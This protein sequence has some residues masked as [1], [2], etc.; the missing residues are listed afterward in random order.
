MHA[1]ADF[2]RAFGAEREPSADLKTSRNLI[3]R[4]LNAV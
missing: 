3:Q 2:L 1:D 4:L